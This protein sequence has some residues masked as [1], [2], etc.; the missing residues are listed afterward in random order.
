MAEHEVT[1]I[2]VGGD[3]VGIIGLKKVL[4][5]VAREFTGRPDQEIE[6][7]LMKRLG[8]WNYIVPSAEEAYAAAFFRNTKN[9]SANLFLKTW[10]ARFRSGC[11]GPAARV[12]TSSKRPDGGHGGAESAGGSGSCARRQGDR[13]LRRDGQPL[14]S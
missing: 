1:Q 7:E 6:T 14:P 9:S 8:R 3:R 2:S 12:A 4:E 10:P 11:W 13:Q 5:A